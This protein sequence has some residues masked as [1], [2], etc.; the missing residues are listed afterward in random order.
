[1]LHLTRHRLAIL[2]LSAFAGLVVAAS[3]ASA[4]NDPAPGLS[5]AGAALPGATPFSGAGRP[6]STKR[7]RVRV[8]VRYRSHCGGI[9]LA[10]SG[11]GTAGLKRVDV[12]AGGKRIGRDRSRPYRL[13]L[14][15]KRLKKSRKLKIRLVGSSGKVRTISR[16]LRSCSSSRKVSAHRSTFESLPVALALNALLGSSF[17]T[18]T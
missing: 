12:R 5:P 10:L 4:T 16:T 18:A 17:T 15:N 9:R 13:V 14:G 2:A 3:P 1:M 11:A 7:G 8:R 6:A